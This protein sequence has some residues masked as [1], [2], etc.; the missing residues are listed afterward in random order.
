MSGL[1]RSVQLRLLV[2]PALLD[3]ARLTALDVHV[4]KLLVAAV[5]MD[6]AS[7]HRIDPVVATPADAV[8]RRVL[9][10]KADLRAIYVEFLKRTPNFIKVVSGTQKQL[11]T[12]QQRDHIL[13]H[14]QPAGNQMT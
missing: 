5:I 9:R 14:T 12:T 11:P 6:T 2:L 8:A 4:R 13:H 1:L 3:S 10:H 7:G